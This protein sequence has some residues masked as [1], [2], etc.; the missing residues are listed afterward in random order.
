M[1][2]SPY[3]IGILVYRQRLQRSR[4]N[5]GHIQPVGEP[6]GVGVVPNAELGGDSRILEIDGRETVVE[7]DDANARHELEGDWHGH[8]VRGT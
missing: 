2:C 5:I 7:S 1:C 4:E 8:E 3:T 6:E